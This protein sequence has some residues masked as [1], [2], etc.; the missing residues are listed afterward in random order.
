MVGKSLLKRVFSQIKGYNFLVRYWDGEEVV[1]GEGKPDFQLAF[2]REPGPVAKGADISLLFGEAYIRGE[3]DIAGNFDAIAKAIE[4]GDNFFS[5]KGN[6]IGKILKLAR[7]RG[8][9]PAKAQQK[10]NI[11]SHYDLGNDFFLSGLIPV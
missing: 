3:L 10:K 8:L 11:A 7:W 4:D 2:W 6:F 9:R 1:Y 5:G